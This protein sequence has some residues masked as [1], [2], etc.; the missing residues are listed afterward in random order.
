MKIDDLKSVIGA[1]GGLARNNLFEVF[2][3]PP[4]S[5]LDFQLLVDVPL[6]CESVSIPGRQITSFEYPLHS[7]R[8]DVKVPNGY[9]NADIDLTFLL[10]NDFQIK[11]LIES[12][13]DLVVDKQSYSVN[14][15]RDY[16]GNINIRSLDQR[17]SNTYETTL[18]NAWPI[19][20]NPIEL[21]NQN[22]NDYTRFQVTFTFEDFG[23]NNNNL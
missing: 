7:F 4:Q 9:L 6:L 8:Q 11:K 13:S 3:F 23:N 20:I 18:F 1:R 19:T 14:Y 15:L 5:L 16:C 12:W 2:L 21:E 17:G 22:T 10:T